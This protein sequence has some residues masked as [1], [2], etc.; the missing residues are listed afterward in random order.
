MVPN[1]PRSLS[2]LRWGPHSAPPGEEGTK[3][4]DSAQAEL[5]FPQTG[6]A[7][8][9]LLVKH[10]LLRSFTPQRSARGHPPA[11]TPLRRAPA[12]QGPEGQRH[13]GGRLGESPSQGTRGRPGGGGCWPGHRPRHRC[14]ASQV[15]PVLHTGRLDSLLTQSSHPET[16]EWSAERQS[17]GR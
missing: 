13:V 6:P 8:P 9:E 12:T 10:A 3:P 14:T 4:G 17:V 16:S 15:R 7:D 11:S 5:G 1:T 2:S